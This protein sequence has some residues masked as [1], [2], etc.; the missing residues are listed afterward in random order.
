VAPAARVAPAA[1]VAPAAQMHA[2]RVISP[3]G[4]R[5]GTSYAISTSGNVYAWGVSYEGQAGDGNFRIARVPVLIAATANNA[6]I[7]VPRGK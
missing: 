5:P 4:G 3:P 7:N 6:V 2:L 1:P